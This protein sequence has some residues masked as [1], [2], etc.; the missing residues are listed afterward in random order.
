VVE[1]ALFVIELPELGGRAALQAEGVEA[2]A[3]MTF[4]G[5]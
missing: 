3:L 2:H 5:H 1:H 4:E